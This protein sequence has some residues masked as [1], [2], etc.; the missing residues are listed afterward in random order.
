MSCSP[1]PLI[2]LFCW[3][4]TVSWFLFYRNLGYFARQSSP[5]AA[6][7]CLWEVQHQERGDLDSLASAL[8]EIGRIQVKQSAIICNQDH[9]RQQGI[10][11]NMEETKH[12]ANSLNLNYSKNIAGM[13]EKSEK[14]DPI[15]ILDQSRHSTCKTLNTDPTIGL[16]NNDLDSE[17]T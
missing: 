2:I 3:N 13:L 15:L 16:Y 17:H 6:I 1:V 14:I 11:D 7:L 10:I 9:P 12:P 5:S 8:E 4:Q